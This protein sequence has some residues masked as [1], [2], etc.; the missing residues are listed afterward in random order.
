MAGRDAVGS[1]GAEGA[2]LREALLGVEVH[3][4]PPPW[5]QIERLASAPGELHP[6]SGPVPPMTSQVPRRA[7]DSHVGAVQASKP[8]ANDASFRIRAGWAFALALVGTVALGPWLWQREGAAEH[9]VLR[10]AA[11]TEAI[12]RVEQPDTTAD[13]FAIEL[14]ALGADVVRA[15]A[16]NGI[17]L[18]ISAPAAVFDAVNQRLQ[19]LETALDAQGRLVLRVIPQEN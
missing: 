10:G 12:W 7:S 13:A 18:T 2:K 6:Q 5:T 15:T 11:S 17:Q 4:E 1:P 16:P 14:R 3:A 9:A 19:P 8:V